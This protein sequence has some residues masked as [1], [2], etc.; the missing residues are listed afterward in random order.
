M[1]F[2]MAKGMGAATARLMVLPRLRY[3]IVAEEQRGIRQGLQLAFTM[4]PM[5]ACLLVHAHASFLQV[6]LISRLRVPQEISVL[7]LFIYI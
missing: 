5:C 7:A 3:N 4:S 1:N 2:G 6:D